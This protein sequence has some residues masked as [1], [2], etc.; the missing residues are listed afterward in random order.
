MLDFGII[1]TPLA[2]R[3]P[4]LSR[5]AVVPEGA[6]MPTGRRPANAPR[7]DPDRGRWS[8]W[9]AGSDRPEVQEQIRGAIHRGLIRVM[10]GEG[11]RVRI[12]PADGGR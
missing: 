3:V 6:G 10:P 1:A 8:D 5:G 7:P 9:E 11:G 12:I 4:S 2:A